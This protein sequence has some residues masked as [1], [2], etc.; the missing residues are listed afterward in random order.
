MDGSNAAPDRRPRVSIVICAL[1]AHGTIGEVLD[2]VVAD[3]AH[4]PHEVIVVDGSVDDLTAQVVLSRSWSNPAIRLVRREGVCGLVPAAIAG[5][6]LARGDVL[7]IVDSRREYDP[8]LIARMVSRLDGASVDIA[9]ASRH[10]AGGGSGLLGHNTGPCRAG[11]AVSGLLLGLRLTDPMGGC[12][13][14]SRSWYAGVRPWLAGVGSKILIDIGGALAARMALFLVVSLT[15]LLM[16]LMIV[17]TSRELGAPFWLSQGGATLTAM[18][19]NFMLHNVLTFRDQ[20]LR[21]TAMWQGLLGFYVACLGG[22]MVSE[23]A[24]AG[25]HALTVPWFAAGAVGALLGAIWN[26]GAVQRLTWRRL[27]AAERARALVVSPAGPAADRSPS[28]LHI[29][30]FGN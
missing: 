26:F 29:P 3:L 5:G 30:I 8:R 28:G 6:D 22:A 25:L 7:A 24:A 1:D 12:F 15:G 13:V 4:L 10:P 14:M 23:A 18:S 17:A 2:E 21:G 11:S 16:H 19:W 27:T 20:R 9:V